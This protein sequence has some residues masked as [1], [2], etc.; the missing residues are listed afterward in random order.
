M[1]TFVS[2]GIGFYGLLLSTS[3][4]GQYG[5]LSSLS[6]PLLASVALVL[7]GFGVELNRKSP[8]V[9][10]MITQVAYL[11][12][13]LWIFPIIILGGLM[14]PAGG[15][16]LLFYT[17]SASIVNTGHLN[18]AAFNYQS[19]PL[20]YVLFAMVKELVPS[21]TYLQVYQ[22][23]PV[24]INVFICILSYK[25]FSS[26]LKGNRALSLAGV[27]L[28]QMVN[29]GEQ[30]TTVSPFTFGAIELYFV[31]LL[32]LAQSAV[33][34]SFSK[35]WFVIYLI[36]IVAS[37]ATHPFYALEILFGTAGLALLLAIERQI[38]A[39]SL[40]MYLVVGF[41]S[42]VGWA[43]FPGAALFGSSVPAIY[44]SLVNLGRLVAPTVASL[45]TATPAH[46]LVNQ[47]KLGIASVIVASAIPAVAIGLA[48]R[49]KSILRVVAFGVGVLLTALV[50]GN[51]EGASYNVYLFSSI[52]PLLLIL[53]F[54]SFTKI[55]P[56]GLKL[57]LL[58]GLILMTPISFLVLDG[59][60][61]SEAPTGSAIQI[62]DYFSSHASATIP[63]P[64]IATDTYIGFYGPNLDVLNPHLTFVALAPPVAGLLHAGYL[65]LGSESLQIA[66][67]TYQN[68]TFVQ[69]ASMSA[70]EDSHF[71]QVYS[72]NYFTLYTKHS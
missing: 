40:L 2:I 22:T 34:N 47:F 70:E 17:E 44:N 11:L 63:S 14:F 45:S 42:I 58:F 1:L 64:E 51:L 65:V 61:V 9:V 68:T 59:N 52:L 20:T 71:S 35:R 23:A 18:Q 72:S 66:E 24:L 10:V 49:D 5:L 21:M 16:D 12:C 46:I 4:V 7:L 33:A 38:P 8:S 32:I 50:A 56:K 36:M 41:Y 69:M 29:F 13:C 60:L 27:I 6:K 62:A 54:L 28:L 26:Y 31:M 48:K 30:F 25:F 15:H 43:V 19:W 57:A 3:G 55:S 37:S 39:Q 53:D 67:F